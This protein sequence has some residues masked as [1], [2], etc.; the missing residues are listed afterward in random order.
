[1]NGQATERRFSFDAPS[2]R[3]RSLRLFSVSLSFSLQISHASG[4]SRLDDSHEWERYECNNEPALSTLLRAI[5]SSRLRPCYRR[6]RTFFLFPPLF[7]PLLALS[8]RRFL[9]RVTIISTMLAEQRFRPS[10]C[11]ARQYLR[12]DKSCSRVFTLSK[13]REVSRRS[14]IREIILPRHRQPTFL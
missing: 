2:H 3:A 9:S 4:P 8:A 13:S 5:L 1:M 11:D 7:I 10:G 14:E 6:R 12:A